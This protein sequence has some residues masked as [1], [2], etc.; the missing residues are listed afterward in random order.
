VF[1]VALRALVPGLIGTLTSLVSDIGSDS[2]TV[3]RTN[4]YIVINESFAN[5]PWFGQGFGTYL[6]QTY[7]ILDNQY[8][9]SLVETGAVGVAALLIV[10]IAGWVLARSARRASLAR[11]DQETAHLAQCFAASMAV[12]LFSFGTFDAFSFPMVANLAF[13]VLGCC[14]ALWRLTREGASEHQDASPADQG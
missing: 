9:L 1:M 7:R 3:T 10:L 8:L 12:A 11:G 2:S 14:G 4:D 6:P 13:L 5:H